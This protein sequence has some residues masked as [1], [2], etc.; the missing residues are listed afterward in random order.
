MGMFLKI[1]HLAV[2]NMRYEKIAFNRNLHENPYVLTKKLI[3]EQLQSFK[4]F[5]EILFIEDKQNLYSAQTD[6]AEMEEKHRNLFN[7]IWDKYDS[8]SYENYIER[9][10]HR[11]RVNNLVDLIKGKRCLDIGCGNGNF[12]FA[13]ADLGAE[14][15]AGVDFGA[16][17]VKYA[18]KIRKTRK[19]GGKCEFKVGNVYH[20]SFKSNSFDLVIQNGVFHHLNNEYKAISE[21]KRVLRKGGYFWYYTDGEGGISH[22]LWDRSVFLLR[23][24]P[25]SF[26]QKVFQT[27]NVSTNKMV[28]IMDGLKATYRHTSWEKITKVLA[29]A[30]FGNFKRLTGGFDTDF[31]LDVIEADPYGKEKFG[32]GDLRILAQLVKK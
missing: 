6:Q 27:M 28:H 29:K 17:S 7:L 1:V 13:L 12:C 11:L 22:V 14:F 18:N 20:L 24:A 30:G 2:M 15:A 5:T 3:E 8:A 19:N 32:E 23:K 21:A 10:K 4:N 9:Y 16:H 25:A 31:D 26:I